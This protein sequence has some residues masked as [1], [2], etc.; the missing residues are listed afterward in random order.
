MLNFLATDESVRFIAKLANTN[1]SNM[2]GAG[3]WAYS[4]KNWEYLQRHLMVGSR[5]MKETEE[6]DD[7]CN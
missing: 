5:P 4:D 3:R 7:D 6:D 1:D 2:V